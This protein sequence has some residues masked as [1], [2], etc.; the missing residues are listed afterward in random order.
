MNNIIQLLF[1]EGLLQSI[2]NKENEIISTKLLDTY[3]D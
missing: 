1:K 2:L 3:E